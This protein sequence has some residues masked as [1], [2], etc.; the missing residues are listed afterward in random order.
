M[1]Y[2][3]FDKWDLHLEPWSNHREH[4]GCEVSMEA[5]ASNE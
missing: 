1:S 3:F 2:L 4:T 5:E